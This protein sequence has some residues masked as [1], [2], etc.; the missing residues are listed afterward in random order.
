MPDALARLETLVAMSGLS[1]PHEAVRKQISSAIN[2]II[3]VARLGDGSRKLVSIQEITGM[4]GNVV[5]MQ[6]LLKYEQTGVTESG[7]VKGRFTSSGIRPKF[8]EKFAALGIELP[9]PLFDPPGNVRGL[10]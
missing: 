9:R 3:Q 8:A 7:A 1:I 6:E 5:T 4:E 2:V 10:K